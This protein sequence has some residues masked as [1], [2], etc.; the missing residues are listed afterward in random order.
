M[1]TKIL[2]TYDY[3]LFLGNRSGSVKE[4]IIDPTNK[5]L[6]LHR[7]TKTNAIFF[8]DCTYLI[9][10][11]RLR[12]ITQCRENY[13]LIS[14]QINEIISL[15]HKIYP[16]IHP[17][18][19]DAIYLENEDQWDLSNI[20]YYKF[21]SLP[22]ELKE[23]Y[24]KNSMEIIDSFVKN[25]YPINSYRAGGWSIQPFGQFKSFFQKYGIKNDLSVIPGKLVKSNAHL[26]DFNMERITRMYQYNDEVNIP[27][28]HGEFN[29]F[30]I[31]SI[32]FRSIEKWIDFKLSA[33]QNKLTTRKNHKTINVEIFQEF[34][35]FTTNKRIASSFEALNL[36]RVIKFIYALRRSKYYHFIS[37][38]KLIN[39]IDLF[40]MKIL[41]FFMSKYDIET[42]FE[43]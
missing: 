18:W 41:L 32:E 13:L 40:W 38:P 15:N 35:Y 2:L 36:L 34:D 3:E 42:K 10:L 6:E 23:Y 22:I 9:A 8:I 33:I 30:P 19:H 21:E 11:N 4:C 5:I 25:K 31:S 17:H 29:E 24:F 16:H 39:S 43:E 27:V 1:K 28:N 26:F 12:H 37:H 20:R 7:K 14:G